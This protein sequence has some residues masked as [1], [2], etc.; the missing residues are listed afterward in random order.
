MEV[1]SFKGTLF[2]NELELTCLHSSMVP[3]FAI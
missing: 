1:N 3:N 2:L